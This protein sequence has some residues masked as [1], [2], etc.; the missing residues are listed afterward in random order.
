MEFYSKSTC[1][2][3]TKVLVLAD[4]HSGNQDCQ[5]GRLSLHQKRCAFCF[6]TRMLGMEVAN[7]SGNPCAICR[8]SPYLALPCCQKQDWRWLIGFDKLCTICLAR[9]DPRHPQ[10]GPDMANSLGDFCDICITETTPDLPPPPG[11][12]ENTC[13]LSVEPT[14]VEEVPCTLR[15]KYALLCTGYC[16]TPENFL[17]NCAVLKYAQN[18]PPCVRLYKFKPT[19]LLNC[20]E[21]DFFHATGR[22]LFC[23]LW[24]LP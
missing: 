8:A 23:W 3:S 18:K 19:Q 7:S 4:K 12:K 1:V 10:V 20:V 5:T 2:G 15:S 24:H 11:P 21:P 16:V 6:P 14:F 9:G 22:S 13:S 17:P